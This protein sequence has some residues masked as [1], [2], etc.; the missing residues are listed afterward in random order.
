MCL[1]VDGDEES[2][3]ELRRLAGDS[4]PRRIRYGSRTTSASLA[5]PR[6]SGRPFVLLCWRVGW[7]SNLARSVR[8]RRSA[9]IATGTSGHSACFLPA[10]KLC[11]VRAVALGI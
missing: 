5:R 8:M 4:F 7:E 2:E 1:L 11:S 9:A 10:G 3:V 6:R